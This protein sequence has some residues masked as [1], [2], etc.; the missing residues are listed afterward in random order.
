MRII[1][2]SYKEIQ[3][4]RSKYNNGEVLHLNKA[5]IVKECHFCG[6]YYTPTHHR[7]VYCTKSCSK[8]ALQDQKNKWKRENWIP[9]IENGTGYLTEKRKENFKEE[10]R[11]IKGELRRL[12]LNKK[13]R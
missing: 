4:L 13:K 7:Q 3:C 11:Q 2:L 10:S 5:S 9:K 1:K 12:G 8:K 6:N